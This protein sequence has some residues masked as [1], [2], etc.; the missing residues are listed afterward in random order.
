[1]LVEIGSFKLFT[2]HSMFRVVFNAWL[3]FFVSLP[4]SVT[5][6]GLLSFLCSDD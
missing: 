1:M 5:Q 4:G 2:R 6:D 3:F